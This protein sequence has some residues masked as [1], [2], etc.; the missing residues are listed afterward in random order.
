[1]KAEILNNPE[2]TIEPITP[3]LT[4]KNPEDEIF[5][6]KFQQELK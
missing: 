4:V 5:L 3:D 6:K 2:A 1:M